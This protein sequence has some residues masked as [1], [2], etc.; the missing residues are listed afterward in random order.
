M[1][2]YVP[3]D[4]LADCAAEAETRGYFDCDNVPPWDTWVG[5]VHEAERSQYLISWVPPC[6]LQL[7]GRGIEVNPEECIWWLADK[8]KELAR[9][10]R[11]RGML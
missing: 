1:L 10:L 6:F 4:N 9:W 8:D 5:Y 2:G 7:A 11:P 3:D